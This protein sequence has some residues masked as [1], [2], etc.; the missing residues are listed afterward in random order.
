MTAD[1]HGT[2]DILVIGGG[3]AGAAVAWN[4]LHAAAGGHDAPRLLLLER[5][6]QPGHHSTGRSAALFM[7]TYGP[8][9]ARALT[10]A[11]RAFYTAP[12]EGL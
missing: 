3:I 1:A 11:S 6:A 7:E 4:L 5:E 10:R 9:Q 8:P 2:L 12:P